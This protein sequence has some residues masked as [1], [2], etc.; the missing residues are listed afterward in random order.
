MKRKQ[1]LEDETEVDKREAAPDGMLHAVELLIEN[2]NETIFNKLYAT[3]DEYVPDADALEEICQ[4][5]FDDI[6]ALKAVVR[7]LR[8]MRLQ[9]PE[10]IATAK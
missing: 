8:G 1:F 4:R 2:I 5:L 6:G 3:D 9:L 10:P 7:Q